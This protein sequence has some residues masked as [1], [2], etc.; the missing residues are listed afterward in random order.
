MPNSVAVLEK[1]EATDR[2]QQAE[3]A[4]QDGTRAKGHENAN[5]D[6]AGDWE[7]P[8]PKVDAV[9]VNQKHTHH[10]RIEQKS[11]KESESRCE[12]HPVRSEMVNERTARFET[13]RSVFQAVSANEPVAMLRFRTAKQVRKRE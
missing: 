9:N 8:D 7:S 6:C 11:T 13:S 3:F 2:C 1:I 12:T 5:P 10:N 4:E